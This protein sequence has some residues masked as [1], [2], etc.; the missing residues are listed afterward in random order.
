MVDMEQRLA[1]LEEKFCNLDKNLALFGQSVGLFEK[2]LTKM[3]CTLDSMQTMFI[4]LQDNSR[5]NKE[6]IDK[7]E[8]KID[9]ITVENNISIPEFLKKYGLPV[10]VVIMGIIIAIQY[11]GLIR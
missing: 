8:K 5:I 10:A 4:Q 2:V 9:Q 11:Y 1:V 7:L 3:D 6:N